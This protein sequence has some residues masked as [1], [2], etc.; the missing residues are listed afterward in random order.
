MFEIG[1]SLRA[2]QT[3]LLVRLIFL[4]LAAEFLLLSSS[5]SSSF[6]V[7]LYPL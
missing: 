1:V 7:F 6:P 5:P 3:S 4:L 2:S